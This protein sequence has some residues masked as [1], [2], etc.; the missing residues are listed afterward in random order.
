MLGIKDYKKNEEKN[1][2]TKQCILII[3][4]E[5]FKSGFTDAIN[6]NKQIDEVHK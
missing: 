1:I 5:K 2:N 4:N 6:L 3:M